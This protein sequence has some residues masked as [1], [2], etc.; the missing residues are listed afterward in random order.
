MS[1]TSEQLRNIFQSKFNLNDWT[2]FL[3]NYFGART[4]RQVPEQLE[5]DA[6]EGKGAYLGQKST[7]DNYEIGLFY[8]S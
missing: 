2:Q 3:I 1:Y 7:N 5:L 6:S 4:I 8:F